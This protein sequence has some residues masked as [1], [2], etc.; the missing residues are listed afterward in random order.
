MN[1]EE[2]EEGSFENP[3]CSLSHFADIATELVYL[4]HLRLNT[5]AVQEIVS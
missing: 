5:Q 1:H 3:M 4:S 2:G